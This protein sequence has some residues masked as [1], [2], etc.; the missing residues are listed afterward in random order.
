M[1]T[2][3]VSRQQQADRA[4]E[5]TRGHPRRLALQ[6][7]KL[8]YPFEKH[9][10]RDSYRHARER[11]ADARVHAAAE[12]QVAARLARDVVDVGVRELTL[13]PI[14]GAEREDHEIPAPHP[15]PVQL[16]VL[17]EPSAEALGGG[18]ES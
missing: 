16:D 7:P 12:T 11:R 14:R 1:R 15:L 9:L 17:S 10:E 5:V 13:V 4:T 18:V 2:C 8:R 6:T 3:S